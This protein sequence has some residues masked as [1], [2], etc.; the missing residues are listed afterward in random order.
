MAPIRTNSAVGGGFG[1][2]PTKTGKAKNKKPKGRKLP[3][4]FSAPG[5]S[6]AVEPATNQIS[7]SEV[8]GILTVDR[9]D[10]IEVDNF[11]N[12]VPLGI[13]L[14]GSVPSFMI[15]KQGLTPD[16]RHKE[17][18]LSYLDGSIEHQQSIVVRYHKSKFNR[19]S[20]AK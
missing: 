17:R 7:M 1:R 12:I 14:N 9:R 6:T 16:E 13:L 2:P 18:T 4:P 11:I 20:P 8:G 10:D 3:D 19:G 5:S 15:E